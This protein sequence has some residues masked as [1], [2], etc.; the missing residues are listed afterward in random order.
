MDSIIP[1]SNSLSR[2]SSDLPL[3][4]GTKLY[5]AVSNKPH[6]QGVCRMRSSKK[7]PKI[8]L[9]VNQNK[10]EYIKGPIPGESTHRPKRL[11]EPWP[12]DSEKKVEEPV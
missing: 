12:R 9:Q 2:S 3:V 4:S 5:D 10:A 7:G 1:L 6:P 8:D 11:V